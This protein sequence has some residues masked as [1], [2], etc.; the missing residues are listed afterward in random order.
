MRVTD[1]LMPGHSSL[2]SP[3][4]SSDL[5]SADQPEL[6]YLSFTLPVHLC[7]S[8]MVAFARQGPRATFR[9]L[10][11]NFKWPWMKL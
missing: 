9:T 2:W 4:Q 5:A 10:H 7:R 1:Y 8:F 3:D 6:L 11:T